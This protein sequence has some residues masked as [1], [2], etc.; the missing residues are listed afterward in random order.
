MGISTFTNNQNTTGSIYI[1]RD[2][3]NVITSFANHFAKDIEE[4][5][6]TQMLELGYL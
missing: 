4:K 6:S 1:I 3:R 2:P 5:F